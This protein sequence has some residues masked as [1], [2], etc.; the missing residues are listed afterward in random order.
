[1]VLYRLAAEDDTGSH[2]IF[3]LSSDSKYPSYGSGHGFVPYA[4][5]P[6]I[7]DKRPLDEEDMLHDPKWNGVSTFWSWRGATNVGLLV[8]LITW[9]LCLFI[10]Y[11]VLTFIRNN[12][13]NLAIGG[14]IRINA[15]G[16]APIL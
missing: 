3:S 4:Y 5:D 2:S 12:G 7:D 16:Q 11:P 9:L 8:L 1:M 14:H 6:A 15:T 13:R 10:F